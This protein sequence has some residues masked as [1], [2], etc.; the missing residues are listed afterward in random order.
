MFTID[1]KKSRH[2]QSVSWYLDDKQIGTGSTVAYNCDTSGGVFSVVAKGESTPPDYLG[3]TKQLESAPQQITVIGTEPI[4]S[5]LNVEDSIQ[6][7]L[8][9]R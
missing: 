4:V 8:A 9:Q 1:P 2:Y 5:L 3:N 7:L 6:M